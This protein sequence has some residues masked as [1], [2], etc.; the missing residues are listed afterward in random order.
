MVYITTKKIFKKNPILDINTS[1]HNN[2]IRNKEVPWLLQELTQNR[3]EGKG[4]VL[5]KQQ[6]A[7]K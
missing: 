5:G 7:H 1:T 4:H 3:T 6:V 2:S